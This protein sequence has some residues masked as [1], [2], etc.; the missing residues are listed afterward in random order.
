M[1][2]VKYERRKLVL[3]MYK[4]QKKKTELWNARN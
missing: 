2:L 3:K 4:K 1:L